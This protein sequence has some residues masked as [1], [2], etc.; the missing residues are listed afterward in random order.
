MDTDLVCPKR[1]GKTPE[2]LKE[3][4]KKYCFSNPLECKE[5]EEGADMLIRAARRYAT[6]QN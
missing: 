4:D 1:D 2:E 3:L 6:E 5:C